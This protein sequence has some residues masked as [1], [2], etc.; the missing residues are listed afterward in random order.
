MKPEADD[1]EKLPVWQVCAV[2]ALRIVV[3][4]LFVMSGLVK[5]IDV[6]GSVFKFE[7]YFTVWGIAVP[8]SLTVLTAMALCS[9]E[10]LL[11][12]MLLLGCFRRTTVWLLLAMMAVMLPLTCYIWLKDPVSD[13][14]CFGDFLILS[15][16]AT[17]VK[18]IFITAALVVLAFMNRKVAGL[19][20]P[21][22]QWICGVACLVFITLVELYGFNIQPMIDFRSFP[23]G[24]SLVSADDDDESDS[25]VTDNL[26]FIYEK[27]GERKE[28]SA[29][30]LPDS[31]WTFVDRVTVGG[32]RATALADDRTELT[33][34]DS[35]GENI[36]RDVISGAGPEMVVIVPQFERADIYYI[37]FINELNEMMNR[38]NGSLVALTDLAPDSIEA[39]RDASMAEFPVYSAE[40]TTLKELSR[41]VVSIVM[42]DDGVIRWKRNLGSIDVEKLVSAPELRKALDSQK[43]DGQARLIRWVV[44]LLIVLLAIL[45]IDRFLTAIIMARKNGQAENNS[46][47]L[48]PEEDGGSVA[49]S[50]PSE[51]NPD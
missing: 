8:G 10:F 42:L 22:S 25:S 19:Y 41:G 32:G 46:V 44:I 39:M 34:F 4:A 5:G 40:S 30:E 50:G 51:T 23:A 35:E 43:P 14:G 12:A 24:T 29:S 33:V 1:R 45:A 16:A 3:G 31:T 11:G 27:D 15:N 47:N 48:Q 17:F 36:T 37:S 21:Y 9:A 2:W 49:D 6:W 18:N 20:N 28:F 38:L 26:R 13:C 7:E